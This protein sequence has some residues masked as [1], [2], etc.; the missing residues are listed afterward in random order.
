MIK[1]VESKKELKRFVSLPG[2]IYKKDTN[3]VVPMIGADVASLDTKTNF[4]LGGLKYELYYYEEDEKVVGRIGAFISDEYN[5]IQGTE[6]VFFGLFE[7]ADDLEV[8]RALLQSVEDFAAR[9][10]KREIMGPVDMTPNYTMGLLIQ[11]FERP[12]IMTPYNKPY[13][14]ALL[15]ALG[16]EKHLDLYAYHHPRDKGVPERIERMVP[17]IRKRYPN[18]VIQSFKKLG[19]KA[20]KALW[21]VYNNAFQ[22]NWGFLPLSEKETAHLV[23]YILRRGDPDLTYFAFDVKKPIGLLIA[24]PDTAQK[25]RLRLSVLGVIP[26]CR[27]KGVESRLAVRLLQDAFYLKSYQAVEHSLVMENNE[28]MNRFIEKESGCKISRVYR[29]Y[30]KTLA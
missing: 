4:V 18:I 24:L 7:C 30:S 28:A 25:D 5:Q 26:K 15:E 9:E 20:G 12:A 3:W 13:Y 8:A 29:L 10:N 1:R 23:R 27:G 6:R 19:S 14:Q 16:Y 22:D 2:S 11:G 17:L 21:E